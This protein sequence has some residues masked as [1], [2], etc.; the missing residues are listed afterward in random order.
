MNIE[1]IIERNGERESDD[2]S[3]PREAMEY[4]EYKEDRGWTVIENT[5]TSEQSA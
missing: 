1:I 4:I 3:T 5:I 2:F